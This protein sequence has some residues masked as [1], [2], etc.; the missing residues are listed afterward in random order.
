MIYD[1]KA[2]GRDTRK[3]KDSG[4]QSVVSGRSE[5]PRTNKANSRRRRVGR[6]RRD[7][8]RRMLYKQTQFGVFSSDE[9][10]PRE[11]TKPIPAVPVY[12]IPRHSAILLFHHSSA[13][14]ANRAKQTQFPAGPDGT[15]PGEGGAWVLYKQTQLWPGARPRH[16]HDSSP[17]PI[18]R[19]KANSEQVQREPVLRLPKERPTLNQVEGRLHEEVIMRNKAKLGRTG[20]S[21]GQD[22]GTSVGQMRQT[23]PIEKKSE[24]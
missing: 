10:C 3:P 22:G 6:G 24:V 19:N 16:P 9:G 17:I 18:V 14:R 13:T 20:A 1:L 15:R 11:Q 2:E 5:E 4:W 8:G 12:D 7:E 21:G 23:K